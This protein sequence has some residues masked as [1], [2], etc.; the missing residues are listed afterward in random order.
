[1]PVLEFHLVEGRYSEAQCERLLVESSKLYAEVLQSPLERVRVFIQLYAPH[2]FATGGVPVS[3]GGAPAPVFHFI[4]LEG[5]P[6]EERQRLLA[7]FTDLCVDIL[8]A[9]RRLVR[10]GC[11]MIAPENWG[12]AGQPASVLRAA[13]VQARADTAAK[14]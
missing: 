2:L 6:V 3:K 14:A 9:E 7:G 5:R 1:M 13:E 12:I 10:G 8:G 11:W 4:A